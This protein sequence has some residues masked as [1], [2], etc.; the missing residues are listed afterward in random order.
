MPVILTANTQNEVNGTPPVIPFGPNYIDP[1]RL[2]LNILR[3]DPDFVFNFFGGI[4]PQN[5]DPTGNPTAVITVKAGT[6]HPEMPTQ[7]F[8]LQCRIWAGV[9]EFVAARVAS[10]YAFKAAHGI[11]NKNYGQ[12]GTIITC[13]EA[14]PGQETVDS[15][16]G[17]A[18]LIS[19]FELLARSN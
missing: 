15:D 2:M 8:V 14:S 18:T 6:T 16:S 17:W 9:N 11:V 3:D 12:F 10:Y 4:L 7:R 19:T 13:I 5:Y 1:I